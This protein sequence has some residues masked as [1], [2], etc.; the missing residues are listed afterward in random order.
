M[1]VIYYFSGTGNS[2]QIARD[3]AGKLGETSVESIAKVNPDKI[4]YPI[5]RLG[6][7]FPCYFGALP[8]IVAE[9]VRKLKVSKIE[10]IFAVSTNNGMS[11]GTL[12][13]I[14]K[15][16]RRLGKDLDAGFSIK[17]PG[18]FI[19]LYDPLPKMSQE[20]RIDNAKRTVKRISEVIA[21]YGHKKIS[22]LGWFMSFL[23][24]RNDR[25]LPLRDKEF[26]V[27]KNCNSCG[28][29]EK[30]CPVQDI[31][32]V[33]GKP[34]WLQKCQLCMACLHWCPEKAIQLGEKTVGRAR[35]TNPNVKL[36][37]IMS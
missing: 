17:M 7:V 16:L 4:E 24:K 9:F 26:W 14:R 37:E 10:Y 11:G 33:G 35:Y 22:R 6:I 30:V 19:A 18:N 3:L 28:I 13:I 32:M 36:K 29:C 20:I 27:D 8:P 12:Y 21:S 34:K 1:N 2:L 23:Q 5:D 15:I 31:Q 25:K